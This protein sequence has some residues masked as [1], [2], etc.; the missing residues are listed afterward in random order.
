M[1][2]LVL[3]K[4]S[5][6]FGGLEALCEISLEI[7]QGERRVI[8]G[9]NGAGKTTLFN[10]IG[11]QLHQTSGKIFL[12]GKEATKLLPYQRAALGL[13]RTFQITNLFRNLTV[14]ENILLAVQALDPA[15]FVLYR[16]I[17]MYKK[18]IERAEALLE[19]WNFWDKQ[20]TLIRNLSYGDQRLIEIIMALAEKPNLLLLDEPTAGL[21]LGETQ[22]VTSAIRNLDKVITVV[23]IEHDMDVAFEIAEWVTVLHQGRLLS[24]GLPRDIQ[25]D[26]K[27][28]EIYLGK[29]KS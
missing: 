25:K 28:R 29:I 14:R 22:V 13:S 9:P 3:E 21:S 1:K 8:I 20:D 7:Q 12:F 10:L 26:P 15:K 19:Q 11:G 18:F 6:M 23:L 4:V 16:P 27:V 17:T 2:P 5:K 24:E